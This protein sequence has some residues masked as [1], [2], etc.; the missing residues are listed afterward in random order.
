MKIITLLTI[1]VTGLL[2]CDAP[3]PATGSG[4][5]DTMQLD[6]NRNKAQID[7]TMHNDTLPLNNR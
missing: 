3:G 1:L 2:A 4:T 5:A 6:P 7:T